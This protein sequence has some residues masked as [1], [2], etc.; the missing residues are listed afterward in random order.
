[1]A[2]AGR[3]YMRT[4]A[5]ISSANTSRIIV[6]SRGLG[7]GIVKELFAGVRDMDAVLLDV[8]GSRLL[9]LDV[10]QF[11]FYWYHNQRSK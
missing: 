7:H 5:G 6:V 10:L 1:M 9:P 8:G 3:T 2:A 4:A 11:P